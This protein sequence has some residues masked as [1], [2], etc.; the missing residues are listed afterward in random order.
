MGSVILIGN[1]A[2]CFDFH[3]DDQG[4]LAQ[5]YCLA[6]I[7]SFSNFSKKYFASPFDGLKSFSGHS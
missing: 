7:N 3:Q 1:L 6:I 2:P 4:D 5:K